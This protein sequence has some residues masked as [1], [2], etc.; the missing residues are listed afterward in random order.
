MKGLTILIILSVVM[1]GSFGFWFLFINPFPIESE[2][3]SYKGGLLYCCYSENECIRA[4]YCDKDAECLIE[5]Y[6]DTSFECT[7][8]RLLRARQLKSE[9]LKNIDTV[10]ETELGMKDCSCTENVCK[11]VNKQV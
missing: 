7:T 10:N 6:R 3:C 1:I 5:P 2:I 8:E 9:T 4:D 11:W